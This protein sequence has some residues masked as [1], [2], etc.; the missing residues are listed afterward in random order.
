MRSSI[1]A[2]TVAEELAR[3]AN[4][5]GLRLRLSCVIL[6]GRALRGSRRNPDPPIGAGKPT[7]PA[8]PASIRFVQE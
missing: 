4:R 6:S 3:G 5:A 2:L 7:R 1:P 8:N